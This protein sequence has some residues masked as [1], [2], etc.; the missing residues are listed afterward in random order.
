MERFEVEHDNLR[1][2]LQWSVTQD[3]DPQTAMN[4]CVKL[5]HFWVLRGYQHILIRAQTMVI[6]AQQTIYLYLSAAYDTELADVL[7]RAKGKDCQIFRA[8]PVERSQHDPDVI[9]LLVD[10]LEALAG[11]LTSAG[12]SQAVVSSNQAI[13]TALSGFFAE[14]AHIERAISSSSSVA[15]SQND[16]NDRLDWVA[17]EERKQRRLWRIGTDNRV[18]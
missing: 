2:A 4:F 18:A 12:H 17:W 10:G 8:S 1:A 15:I 14:Q 5:N 11:T 3:E 9:L 7:A 13:V 16:Q 6:D